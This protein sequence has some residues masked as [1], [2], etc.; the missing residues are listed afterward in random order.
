MMNSRKSLANPL[1]E[2]KE[3]HKKKDGMQA[4]QTKPF[5]FLP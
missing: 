3:S 5:V 4:Y 1:V 2:K